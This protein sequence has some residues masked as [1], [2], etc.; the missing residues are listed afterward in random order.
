MHKSTLQLVRLS[1]ACRQTDKRTKH[2]KELHYLMGYKLRCATRGG[3]DGWR[4][5]GLQCQLIHKIILTSNHREEKK[6][7]KNLCQ[8]PAAKHV[9]LSVVL[10]EAASRRPKPN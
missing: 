2:K 5:C 4:Q 1:S 3:W 6:E 7:K 10:D 9:L 8:T